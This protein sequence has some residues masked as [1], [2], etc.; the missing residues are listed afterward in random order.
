MGAG[1]APRH[2]ALEALAQT[3]QIDRSRLSALEA[4]TPSEQASLSEA[5][6]NV[7]ERQ[8]EELQNAIDNALK[9][10]PMLLRKPILKIL[11]G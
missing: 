8:R 5:V 6:R 7:Q 11:R 3:L 4:L 10:V 2:A 1:K 9:H